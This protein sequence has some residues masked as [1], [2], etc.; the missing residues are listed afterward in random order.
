MADAML[1]KDS[2]MENAPHTDISALQKE[3]QKA[4]KKTTKPPTVVASAD[5]SAST[6]SSRMEQSRNIPA[7]WPLSQQAVLPLQRLVVV[8]IMRLSLF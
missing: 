6:V 8:L 3:Q 5:K 1:R 7:K 4:S 2:L